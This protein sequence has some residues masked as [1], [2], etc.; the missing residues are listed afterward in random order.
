MG[1]ARI[2]VNWPRTSTN[3]PHRVFDA[4]ACGACLVTGLLPYVE[5]DFRLPGIHYHEF[6]T[7]EECIDLIG[8]LLR[9]DT[10]KAAA[11]AGYKL[12]MSQHTWAIRAQQLREIARKEFGL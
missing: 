3:R 6:E 8:I 10:Y 1:R 4:M 2:V 11:E 9:E 12:V 5:G 7:F